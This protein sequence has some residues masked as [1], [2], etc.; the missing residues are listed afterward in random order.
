MHT[1]VARKHPAATN[2]LWHNLRLNQHG[3][4]PAHTDILPRVDRNHIFLA[5]HGQTLV[6]C[7]AQKRPPLPGGLTH[8][9]CLART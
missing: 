9:Q 6:H 1:S 8:V 5:N 3:R 2:T 4:P 7:P